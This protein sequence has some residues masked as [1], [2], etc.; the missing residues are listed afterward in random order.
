MTSVMT[1]NKKVITTHR[2]WGRTDDSIPEVGKSVGGW[3]G[4]R[5]ETPFPIDRGRGG[6]RK[7]GLDHFTRFHRGKREG[8]E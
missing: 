1:A 4:K 5:N 8:G 6:R 2:R 3:E 7:S